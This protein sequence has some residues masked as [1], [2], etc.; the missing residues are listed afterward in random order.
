MHSVHFRIICFLSRVSQTFLVR[1]KLCSHSL[2]MDLE[3]TDHALSALIHCAAA[4][5]PNEGCGLLLGLGRQVRTV[6]P[7]DNVASDPATHFEIDP[8]ALIA[9]HKAARLGGPEIVGFFHSH[10]NGLARPSATDAASAARDGK[11][12]V[13]A[14]P[15]HDGAW[16][17]TCWHDGPDG[18]EELSYAVIAG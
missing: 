13:I 18:F 3:I 5:A 9:T 4:S 15:D 1:I 10:P 7:T 17:I 6:L 12:W 2:G 14:A 16:A 8:V 11:A